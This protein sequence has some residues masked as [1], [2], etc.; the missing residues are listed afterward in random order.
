MTR[1]PAQTLY[2]TLMAWQPVGRTCPRLVLRELNSLQSEELMGPENSEKLPQNLQSSELGH[3]P[4]PVTPG[5]TEL[6]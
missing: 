4:H 3:S 6:R 1:V 5:S 2:I